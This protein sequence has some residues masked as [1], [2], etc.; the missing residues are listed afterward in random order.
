MTNSITRRAVLASTAIGV[1]AG[2]VGPASASSSAPAGRAAAARPASLSPQ[3]LLDSYVRLRGRTD[4]GITFGWLDAL[5]YAVV[6]G[7]VYPLCRVLAAGAAR[8]RKISD[9]RYDAVMLEVAHYVD[10][11]SGELLDTLTM[12]VAGRVVKVPHYRTGPKRVA[13]GIAIDESERVGE[14]IPRS[15]LQ[16]FAPVGTVRLVRSVSQ[17]R[18][19]GDDYFV[20]H[21]EYGRVRPGDPS[22]PGVFYR[23]WTNW[24]GPADT[25][26][27]GRLAS[28][29]CDYSYAA[30]TSWRPWMQMGDTAGHTAENGSGSKI[31]SL[32]E[33][34]HEIWNLTERIHP[35]FIENP[36]RVLDSPPK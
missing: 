6:D 26:L 30:L 5:R 14:G 29:P 13:F 36:E 23:E 2:A 20:R 17:P 28:A 34:P 32:T 3:A 10:M 18:L 24:R 7:E 31:A 11:E 8:F 15:Q 25:A 19:Q 1:I 16:A 9:T 21:E 27:D 12:P 35:D 33:L 4:G 22:V